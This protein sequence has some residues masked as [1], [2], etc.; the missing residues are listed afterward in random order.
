MR[1]AAS[2]ALGFFC[3]LA[4]A[5]TLASPAL[6]AH[7][8]KGETFVLPEG[9]TLDDD[10]YAVG[11]TVAINGTVNGDLMVAARTIIIRG[12]VTGSVFACGREVTVTGSVGR[13]IRAAGEEILI[14]GPVGADAVLGAKSVEVWKT[15][16]VGRDV[17]IA[18]KSIVVADS[19]GDDA[20][21]FG[22]AV[23]LDDGAMIEG[24][25]DYSSDKGLAMAPGAKVKGNVRDRSGDW[26]AKERRGNRAIGRFINWVRGLIGMFIFGLLLVLPFKGFFQ[27]ATDT[28]SRSVLASVGVGLL[29]L[30]LFPLVGMFLLLL[31]IL[32]GGWWI[33]FFVFVLFLFAVATG[34]VV[35]ALGVGR[36]IG[37]LL[38]G[39]GLPI[40]LVLLMGLLALALVK[41]IP[42]LGWMVACVAMLLGFGAL[43]L[44]VAR[45]N[46]AGHETSPLPTM[47]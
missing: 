32:A 38:G 36:W 12:N 22:E 29:M 37:G 43:G 33:S 7:F 28:I 34:Y 10:L 24:N 3:A 8:R 4:F 20:L 18:G 6:A 31:G 42:I 30:F 41:T 23:R 46:R 5:L 14:K 39:R 17:V 13:T 2:R 15:A 25:L 27:R 44:A 47:R 26:K 11:A 45:R 16:P 19:V 1:S 21:L 40:G 35:S 9:E